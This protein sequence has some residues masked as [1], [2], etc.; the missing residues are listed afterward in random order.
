MSSIELA[1]RLGTRQ[2]TAWLIKHKLMA[3]MA[4]ATPASP[5]SK[6]GSRSTTPISAGGGRAA[7]VAAVQPASR[8]SWPGRDHGRAQ[9]QAAQAHRCPGLRKHEIETLAKCDSP[10]AATSSATACPAGRRSGGRLHA[11]PDGHRRWPA[12]PPSGYPSPGSTQPLGQHQDRARRHLPSRQRQARP[13]LPRQLRLALQPSLPAGY[14]D[15]TSGLR[16]CPSTAP[17]PYGVIIA[18]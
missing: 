8:R 1:R 16:L 13:A 4:S 9:A 11:L 7:S 5:S 12:E 6:A 3:A 18:G 17:H 2:P 15:G 14:P 10:P